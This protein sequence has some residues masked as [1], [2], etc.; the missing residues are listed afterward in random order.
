M[1]SVALMQDPP[2]EP[3]QPELPFAFT[4]GIE[5]LENGNALAT[6]SA[7]LEK[8][9]DYAEAGRASEY[10]QARATIAGVVGEL[11]DANRSWETAMS[12]QPGTAIGRR[13]PLANYTATNAVETIAEAAKNHK[14]VMLGEEHVKPQTRSIMIL[15]LRELWDQGYRTLAVETLYEKGI[16]S[17]HENGF[18]STDSGYYTTDPIF[19]A[20][21]REALRLGFRLVPYEVTDYPAEMREWTPNERQNYRE[22]GQAENLK[23]RIYDLDPDGKVVVWAGR[24]H[25]YKERHDNGDGT[26]W[27]PMANV[28][29]ELTGEDPFT[30]YL[31]TYVEGFDPMRERMLYRWA[32]DFHQIDEP[33]IFADGDGKLYGELFDAQVFFPRSRVRDGRPHWLFAELERKSVP[34]PEELILEEGMQLVQARPVGEPDTAIPVDQFVIWPGA[35]VPHLAL[36][37]GEYEVRVIKVDGSGPPKMTLTVD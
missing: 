24:A 19:A 9:D 10:W 3:Q 25:V 30:V 32:A 23:E 20:G 8:H 5:E 27:T 15:L 21:I 2:A 29:K 31:A 34:V 35:P 12:T 13:S 33:T 1:S 14:W 37:S 7:L 16:E 6:Y 11:A 26:F 17:L 4:L 18:A 36:P 28:F 22:R